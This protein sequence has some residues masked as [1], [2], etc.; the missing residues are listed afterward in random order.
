MGEFSYAQP[1]PAQGYGGYG[2]YDPNQ[3]YGTYDPGYSSFQDE[4]QALVPEGTPML[5][6]VLLEMGVLTQE[7]LSAALAKQQETGDSLAQVLL[8]GGWA[9]PDQL[10]VALQTRAAYG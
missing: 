9:A 2:G 4:V 10:A 5:A 6:A 1:D 8:D 7:S 3:G